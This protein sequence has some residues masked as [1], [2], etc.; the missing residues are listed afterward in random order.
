[1]RTTGVTKE[2]RMPAKSLPSNPSLE[3][4]KYQAGDLLNSLNQGNA[5]AFA[6]TREFH[7]RF[8][9]MSNDEIGA[10]KFSLADAQWVIAREYGFESWPKLKHHVEALATAGTSAAGSLSSFK[11]PSGP[12]ELKQKWP[13]GACIVKETDLRQ[14]MEVHTPGKADPVKRELSLKS[15]YAYTVARELP[16]G[17]REVELQHLGFQLEVDSGEYLWRYDSARNS[18]EEQSEIA[19]VFKTILRAKVRYFL[20]ASNQIERMEGVDDLVNRLNV[21]EGAKLKP[22]MT[23]DNQAL[24][25]VLSRILSRTHRPLEDTVWLRNIFGEDYF[26]NRLDPSFFPDKAVQP[27][28]TWTFSRESRKNK[29]S[30]MNVSITRECTV[31]FRSWEM[32]ADRLCARLDLQGTQKTS[33]LA[34][35]KTAKAISPIIEG[36]FSGVVW[37]DPESGRAVEVNVNHDFNV[38]SN[39]FAVPVPYAK[40]AIQAATDHHHQVIIEKLVLVKG[41][42]AAP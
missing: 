12:I 25:N 35:S 33:P 20:D 36:T 11:P 3:H 6:R 14:E 18:D 23:W 38:T 34:E 7:P 32:R 39:K 28:D 22:G 31:T 40:P 16:N 17:G 9:R 19:M 41:P 30:L 5:E 24:D 21:H 4:L 15:Q 42:G 8:T 2:V 37:F 10:A 1:M 29:Q 13:P 26:R 27:G